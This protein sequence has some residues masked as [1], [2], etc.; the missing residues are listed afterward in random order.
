M[1]EHGVDFVSVVQQFLAALDR[2]LQTP[3]HALLVSI[4]IELG[5]IWFTV[6]VIERRAKQREQQRW[7]PSRDHLCASLLGMTERLLRDLVPAH[8]VGPGN[9]RAYSFGDAT[10]FVSIE[11]DRQQVTGIPGDIVRDPQLVTAEQ[12]QKAADA[13]SGYQTELVTALDACRHLDEPVLCEMLQSLQNA[14]A[15][16]HA[17]IET[18]TRHPFPF[19]SVL[20]PTV[21]LRTWL[22]GKADKVYST[23]DIKRCSEQTM[24]SLLGGLV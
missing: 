15:W 11:F 19:L 6:Y 2:F 12:L 21:A 18:G 16:S 23:E 13:V 14:M 8:L 24:K 10:A 1:S 17:H 4:L 9:F 20:Y 22:E 5:A 3:W 7:K